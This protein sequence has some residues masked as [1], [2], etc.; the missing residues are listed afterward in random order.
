[1]TIEEWLAAACA[2]AERRGLADLK[3]LLESLA[4]ATRALRGAE[5]ERVP[6]APE[7]PGGEAAPPRGE[8]AAP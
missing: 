7:P 1:M 8:Q 4:E 5:W 2:D 3:P 6:P